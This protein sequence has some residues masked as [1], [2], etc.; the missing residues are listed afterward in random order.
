MSFEKCWLQENKSEQR[1]PRA[2]NSLPVR[3]IIMTFIYVKL[4]LQMIHKINRE[5]HNNHACK[6]QS[7]D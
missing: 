7:N 6:L 1:L 5:Q 4:S 3:R 2:C